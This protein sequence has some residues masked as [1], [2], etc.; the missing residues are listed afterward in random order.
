MEKARL[1]GFEGGGFPEAA[2]EWNTGR[3]FHLDQI[4][5]ATVD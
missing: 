1:V 5:C 4:D 2:N 3:R